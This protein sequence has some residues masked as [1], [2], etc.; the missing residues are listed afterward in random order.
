VN[1]ATGAAIRSEAVN[2]AVDQFSQAT[3][4]GR[5][6]APSIGRMRIGLEVETQ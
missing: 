1:L 6:I 3:I 4:L 5:L 2:S